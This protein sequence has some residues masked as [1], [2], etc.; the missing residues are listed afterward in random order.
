MEL[1]LYKNKSEPNRLEK[2]LTN[3]MQY[4]GVLRE[5]SSTIN[6]M[7]R[8]ALRADEL[9]AYDYLYI[10]AW[11]RYYFITDYDSIRTGI[12]D[13]TCRVDV[14]MSFADDIK[15]LNVI[16]D[17]Q[18]VNGSMYINDGSWTSEERS[19]YTIKSFSNGFNDNGEYILITA[20]A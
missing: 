2:L 11:N 15:A 5:N 3:S 18:T 14:L 20:G 17:K 6:P 13:I 12:T 1:I 8:I 16:V 4:S 7:I 19:F 10:P 9:A